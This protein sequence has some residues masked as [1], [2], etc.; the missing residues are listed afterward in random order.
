MK[1]IVFGAFVRTGK[2]GKSYGEVAGVMGI[3]WDKEGALGHQVFSCQCPGPMATL[4]I[5]HLRDEDMPCVFSVDMLARQFGPKSFTEV[6]DC[7]FLGVLGVQYELNFAGRL[8]SSMAPAS[9]S[10]S[11]GSNGSAKSAAVP[12]G[13]SR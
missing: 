3:P 9:S 10:S 8:V 11:S 4:I 7:E 6:V 13:A 12:A 5:H 2:D 1:A